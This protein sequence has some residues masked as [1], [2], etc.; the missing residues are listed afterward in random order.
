MSEQSTMEALARLVPHGSRVLD[1]G[2]GNGAMLSYA[3]WFNFS[4]INTESRCAM[5]KMDFLIL[6]KPSA[7]FANKYPLTVK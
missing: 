2:C 4:K 5:Y 3:H 6:Q 7:D 1:L